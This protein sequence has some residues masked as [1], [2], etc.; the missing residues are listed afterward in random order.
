MPSMWPLGDQQ[1]RYSYMD[2]AIFEA[3]STVTLKEAPGWFSHCMNPVVRVWRLRSAHAEHHKD[4]PGK[5]G[6]QD[7]HDGAVGE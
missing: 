2:E 4:K 1:C 5:G 7:H 3:T 6:G